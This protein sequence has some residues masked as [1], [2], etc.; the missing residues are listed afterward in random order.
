MVLVD[1]MHP[2][3]AC[4]QVQ[5]ALAVRTCQQQTPCLER[6]LMEVDRLEPSRASME[7]LPSVIHL[8]HGTPHTIGTLVRRLDWHQTTCARDWTR[9]TV[10]SPSG[11]M[12]MAP[13]MSC[14]APVAASTAT[15]TAPSR[16]AI[17]SA[18]ASSVK[19]RSAA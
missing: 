6:D 12:R 5:Y 8:H 3:N 9:Y 7:N 14:G 2:Y 17:D 15:A 11:P 16:R 10:G 18:K 19:R 4:I 13:S 1:V